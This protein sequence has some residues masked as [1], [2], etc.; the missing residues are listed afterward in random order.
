MEFMF[1]FS[2]PIEKQMGNFNGIQI[3]M[4]FMFIEFL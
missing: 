4:E 2:C 1:F 3:L